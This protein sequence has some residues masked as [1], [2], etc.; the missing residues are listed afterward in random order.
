MKRIIL[1]TSTLIFQMPWHKSRMT[2]STRSTISMRILLG[3][4]GN[5][6]WNWRINFRA[7]MFYFFDDFGVWENFI[8]VKVGYG[9][10]DKRTVR[11]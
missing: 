8:K 11:K 2:N 9:E 1:Y 5:H 6:A 3:Q 4:F 10:L 7:Q